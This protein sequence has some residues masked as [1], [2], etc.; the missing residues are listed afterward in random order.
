Y[1]QRYDAQGN[2]L[3]G[4]F[5]ANTTTNG[6]QKY[7]RVAMNADGDYIVTWSSNGGGLGAKTVGFVGNT[8]QTWNNTTSGVSVSLGGKGSSPPWGVY[9]QQYNGED[10]S[11]N[12]TEFR[13]NLLTQGDNQYS[14]IAMDAS[15]HIVMAW[16]ETLTGGIPGIYAQSYAIGADDLSAPTPGSDQ[17]QGSSSVNAPAKIGLAVLSQH[18]DV[19]PLF[20]GA[21]AVSVA[22]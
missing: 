14:S 12:G 18:P 13:V 10:G 2:P 16:E 22:G 21:P 20:L 8:V 6:D 9:A 5:Q 4:E 7:G 19:R 15:G 11:P 17:G 3:G 1:G